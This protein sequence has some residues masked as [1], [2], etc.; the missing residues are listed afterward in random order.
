M[1]IPRLRRPDQTTSNLTS[2]IGHLVCRD[3]SS[4][5]DHEPLT[6]NLSAALHADQMRRLGR[7][8]HLVLGKDVVGHQQLAEALARVPSSNVERNCFA[9]S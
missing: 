2:H 8:D 3:F 4:H 1:Y 5:I 6:K 7:A 9:V